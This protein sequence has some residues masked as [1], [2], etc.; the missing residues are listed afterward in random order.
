[1]LSEENQTALMT[2]ENIKN[3]YL[4]KINDIKEIIYEKGIPQKI[5]E[6]SIRTFFIKK[7][8]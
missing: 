7:N 2:L 5:S 3:N 8:I 4:K 6:R 1:M